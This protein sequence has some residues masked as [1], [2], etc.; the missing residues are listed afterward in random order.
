MVSRP[1]R[2][3]WSFKWPFRC[4]DSRFIFSVRMATCTSV[5]PVLAAFPP[6]FLTSACFFSVCTCKRLLLLIF[7]NVLYIFPY[8]YRQGPGGSELP[9]RSYK[10]LDFQADLFP[11]QAA[12]KPRQMGLKQPVTSVEGGAL[13]DRYQRADPPVSE[14]GVPGIN[15]VGHEQFF[16]RR[17]QIDRRK[18]QRPADPVAAHDPA[19]YQ[20]GPAQKPF[21]PHDI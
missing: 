19:A 8:L 4:S 12:M 6:C 20:I 21:R 9:L 18:T 7:Y 3:W 15:P 14:E 16:R 2:E 17:F 1:R 13:A 11:V 5:F 10:L